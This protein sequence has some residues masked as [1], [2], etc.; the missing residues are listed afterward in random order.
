MRASMAIPGGFAPVIMDKMIL[1]DG[2]LV[3]NIPVDIARNLCADQ[4]IVVNLVEP[5]ADPMKLQSATQLLSRVDG[6]H[7]HRERRVATVV[8]EAGDVRINVEM[9]DITT[10]DFERVPETVPLGEA[11]A[12]KMSAELAKFSVPEAQYVAW[13]TGVTQSQK[14]EGQLAGV[15]YEGLKRVNPE[16]LAQRQQ[17]QGRRPARHRDDQRGGATHLGAAGLRIRQL[18]P[19]WRS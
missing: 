9:G 8:A 16:Y 3:R 1:S 7:D 15:R 11:A 4:V 5:E 2:G 19:R 14:M 10:A 13:R 12:R 6:R 18:S 17:V